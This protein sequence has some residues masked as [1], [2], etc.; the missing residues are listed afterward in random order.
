MNKNLKNIN[1]ISFIKQNAKSNLTRFKE[2]THETDELGSGGFGSVHKV[3]ALDNKTSTE[4]VVKII[5]DP[6]QGNHSH[7]TIK[8]LHEKINAYSTINATPIFHLYPELLGLP[9]IVFRAIDETDKPVVGLLMYNLIQLGFE[10]YGSDQETSDDVETLQLND[11]FYLAFQFAKVIDFLNKLNFLHSDIKE[12]SIFIHPKRKQLALIDFDSGFHFDQQEKPSTIGA[13][14]YWISDKLRIFIRDKKSN[15]TITLD[16][17]TAEENWVLANGLF[18]LLFKVSPFFFLKD[19]DA[20]TRKAYY[21]NFVWP[22]I[23]FTSSL[24]NETAIDKHRQILSVIHSLEQ[25]GIND[26]LDAFRVTFNQGYIDESKRYTPNQWKNILKKIN[27]R[28]NNIPSLLLFESSTDKIHK[29]NESVQI[30]WQAEKYNRV[31]INGNLQD[32]D[33]SSISRKLQDNK[34]FNIE[35]VND[36]FPIKEQLNIIAVKTPPQIIS[37]QSSLNLRNTLDPIE[38]SWETKYANYVTISGVSQKLKPTDNILLEPTAPINYK[39][40]VYGFF[41]QKISEQV[42]IDVVQPSI[43]YFEWEVNLH[44]GIDNVDLK[45]KTKNAKEVYISPAVGKKNAVG[46]CHVPI[47][48]TTKFKIEAV[49]LFG[50]VT[51]ELIAHPFPVPIITNLMTES[52]K[53]EMNLSIDTPFKEIPNELLELSRLKLDE[54]IN[55][56]FDK[57]LSFTP[58]NLQSIIKLDPVFEKEEVQEIATTFSLTNIYKQIISKLKN[59]ISP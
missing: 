56:N 27:G 29:K 52:P 55:L 24:A 17:R 13:I 2:L 41:D 23:D 35:I 15:R 36:F 47:A 22:K 25:S 42:W 59:Q 16:Q 8:L 4:Y 50:S 54:S 44:E 53:I 10:D 58:L 18:E 14:G 9:F 26:T 28:L 46:S 7:E 12:A 57:H 32:I 11:R 38:L 48:N 43:I 19:S 21:D 33:T 31:Y 20:I 6:T 40:T 39:L 34:V 5:L 49:G 51:K 1:A 30:S 3:I 45:W 37:F